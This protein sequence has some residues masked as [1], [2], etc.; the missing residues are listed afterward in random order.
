[1]PNRDNDGLFGNSGDKPFIE[2]HDSTLR[3]VNSLLEQANKIV[4]AQ[5]IFNWAKQKMKEEG[6]WQIMKSET[7]NKTQD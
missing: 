6:T 5:Y 2:N 4:Y 3:K 7:I 1:M